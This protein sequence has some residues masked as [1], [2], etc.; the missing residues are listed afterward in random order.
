MT[1]PHL[2]V[3]NVQLYCFCV[4]V[5]PCYLRKLAERERVAGGFTPAQPVGTEKTAVSSSGRMTR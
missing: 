1:F 2:S 4:Q 5:L 3:N